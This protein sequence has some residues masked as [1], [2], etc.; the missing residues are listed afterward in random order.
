[1]SDKPTTALIATYAA[2]ADAE[3]DLSAVVS[4]H[5]DADLGH[6]EAAVLIDRG[7]G[8]KVRRHER[9]GGL[10]SHLFH[11][12][13]DDLTRLGWSLPG[14]PVSLVVLCHEPDVAALEAA[15][16]Q[17][18]STRRQAVEHPGLAEGYFEGSSAMDPLP[19][20]TSFE[21]G[22]VGHLGV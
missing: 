17:A 12:V 7:S 5:S 1:M 16:S 19:D 4:A 15:I 6:I 22:S 10:G 14:D 9:L 11:G 21:D 13:S 18:K 2:V 3:A 8:P 20:D